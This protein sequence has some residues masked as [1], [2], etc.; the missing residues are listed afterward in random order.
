MAFPLQRHTRM[1]NGER[2]DRVREWRAGMEKAM[3]KT[4]ADVSGG[5]KK[6]VGLARALDPEIRLLDEPTSGSTN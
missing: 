1:Q 3:R 6:R 2:R 4:P 5:M